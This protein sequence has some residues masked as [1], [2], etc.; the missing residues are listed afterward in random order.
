L[1]RPVGEELRRDQPWRC[2]WR[3]FSQITMTRP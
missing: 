3:R 2:L 1:L